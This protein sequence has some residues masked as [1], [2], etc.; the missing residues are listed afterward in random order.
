MEVL[1]LGNIWKNKLL[2]LQY[3]I[4]RNLYATEKNVN[5]GM[6]LCYHFR[7][8]NSNRYLVEWESSIVMIGYYI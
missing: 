3:C 5:G 2:I 4:I 7:L 8:A 1:L 6:V